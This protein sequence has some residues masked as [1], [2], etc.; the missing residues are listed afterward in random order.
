MNLEILARPGFDP[1]YWLSSERSN[2]KKQLE[3][4][5]QLLA[6]QESEKHNLRTEFQAKQ[7]YHNKKQ[8]EL[9]RYK[10]LI[11]WRRKQ[12]HLL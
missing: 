11:R 1:R 12:K 8:V 6:Y 5:K 3:R 2:N 7:D 10:I 4:Q 9:N